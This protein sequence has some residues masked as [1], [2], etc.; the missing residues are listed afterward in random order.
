MITL[1]KKVIL[2]RFEN[3][4]VLADFSTGLYYSAEGAIISLLEALPGNE[5][6]LVAA[7]KTA[8]GN[9]AEL[10]KSFHDCLEMCK[11]NGLISTQEEVF[12]GETKLENVLISTSVLNEYADMQD[13]LSLDPIHE[14]D[15][16]GWPKKEAANESL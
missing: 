13:L 4:L 14:V 12:K 15:E 5:K 16:S 10:V 9:D 7:I 2:E 3:E 8:L 6:E 1:S 11:T